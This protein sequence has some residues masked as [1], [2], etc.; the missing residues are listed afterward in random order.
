MQTEHLEQD[1]KDDVIINVD[2]SRIF[3]VLATLLLV[4]TGLFLFGYWIGTGNNLEKHLQNQE[5]YQK[6]DTNM[7][8]QGK[9][10]K[11]KFSKIEEKLTREKSDKSK[12]SSPPRDNKKVFIYKNPKN[13]RDIYLT[14]EKPYTVQ[15][16]TFVN[17]NEA[18]NVFQKLRK[19]DVEA[20][21]VNGST[22]RGKS[23]YSL[24]IGPF[25]DKYEA[26]NLLKELRKTTLKDKP[27]ILTKNH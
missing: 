20:Y 12:T 10:T 21:L 13:I 6:I 5:S 27:V 8:Y 22:K 9:L 14:K 24:R 23:I 25:S 17:Q 18:I 2:L 7:F 4:M 26:Y 3:W 19:A 1:Q 11:A 16:K 15:L